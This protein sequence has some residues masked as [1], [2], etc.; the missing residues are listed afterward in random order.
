MVILWV[1]FLVPILI[2]LGVKPDSFVPKET[3]VDIQ[4]RKARGE[5]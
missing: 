5:A 3:A 1:Y 2:W 4:E